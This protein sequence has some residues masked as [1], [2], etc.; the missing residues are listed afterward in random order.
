MKVILAVMNSI[1]TSSE[2]EAWKKDS[3]L[4]EIWTYDRCDTGAVLYQ[5]S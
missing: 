2:N 3:G 1:L 5:L 4:Y